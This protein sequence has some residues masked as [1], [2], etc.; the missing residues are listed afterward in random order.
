LSDAV[1]AW[2][3]L[4]ANLGDA[5]ASLDSALAAIAALP[6]TL[7]ER[8]SSRYRSA[9]LQASGPDFLNAVVRVRTRLAPLALLDA[10]L[11]I[12]AA[13]GR[14]RSH[15]NA[16]RTLDLDLLMHGDTR[17]DSARLTLPHPRLHERA[18]VLAPLVELDPALS[19]PGKGNVADLLDACGDQRCVRLPDRG[20]AATGHS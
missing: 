15:R 4:G 6:H 13:H 12:E 5:Q 8:A 20:S 7:I 3:G 18:F 1:P 14:E 9:P 10:L 2:I 17:I 16:P 11:A 19:V